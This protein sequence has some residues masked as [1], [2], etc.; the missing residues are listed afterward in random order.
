MQFIVIARDHPDS[1]ALKR[2]LK[3]RTSHIALGDELKEK[4]QAIFGVALLNDQ[5]EMNG[6][7]YVVDFPQIEDL[8]A[9]LKKEP[10]V[11][12]EVWDEL[13]IIP[14]KVGPSFA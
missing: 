11:T 6:S 10:Y 4:G 13:E 9:W 12:E 3:A 14:C 7:M 5:G 2:R 8:E 1:E